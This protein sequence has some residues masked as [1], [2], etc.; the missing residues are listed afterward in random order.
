MKRILVTGA[1][2]F[3][4]SRL[5]EYLAEAGHEIVAQGRN[6][7]AWTPRAVI[8]RLEK[9]DLSDTEL[10]V[11][12]AF[13]CVCLL[14]S[15]Q[16]SR[17][18]SW[19]TYY[20]VNSKQVLQQFISSA[21]QVIYVSTLAL[22][23]RNVVPTPK[24]YYELSKLL[25]EQLLRLRK[26]S[27]QFEQV[28][29]VRFPSIIGVNHRA[30]IVYELCR[31]AKQGQPIE[32]FDRGARIRSLIH[33]DDAVAVI[34]KLINN[35]NNLGFLE[36]FDAGSKNS[37]TTSELAKLIVNKTDSNSD[38]IF[39]DKTTRTTDVKVDNDKVESMLG[40]RARSVE[41]SID[42]YM[43]ELDDEI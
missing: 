20:M 14:A 24:N 8:E 4:G 19:E 9:Y 2:G 18:V 5:V 12:E 27:G 42:L 36:E 13:D 10:K 21:K 28:S 26:E 22:N 25:G 17:T 3:L 15:I 37:M 40:F 35:S 23:P 31:L 16:P 30:G 39:L 34:G 38:I 6:I 43:R 33:V 11:T 29:I 41:E 1:T 32:L 7:K